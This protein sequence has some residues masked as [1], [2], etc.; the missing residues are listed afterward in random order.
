MLKML[1]SLRTDFRS[2]RQRKGSGGKVLLFS[3]TPFS[4]SAA[5]RITAFLW[6]MGPDEGEFV[7]GSKDLTYSLPRIHIKQRNYRDGSYDVGALISEECEGDND[8]ILASSL[9]ASVSDLSLKELQSRGAVW[10]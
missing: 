7:E 10:V 1:R 2:R 3:I 8:S 5:R 4:N 6:K 9:R